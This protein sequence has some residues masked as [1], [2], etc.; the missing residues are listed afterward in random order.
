MI[1]YLT[2]LGHGQC[3]SCV[4]LQ[5]S[6]LMDPT[7]QLA[8]KQPT[9]NC[10]GALELRAPETILQSDFGLAVDIWAVG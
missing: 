4:Q 6:S 1:I 2:D 9:A 7:A 5:L 8:G 3:L 10:F